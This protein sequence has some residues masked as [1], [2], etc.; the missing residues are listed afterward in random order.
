MD[1]FTQV[2]GYIVNTDMLITSVLC[3][4]AV[5]VILAVIYYQLDQPVQSVGYLS[6]KENNSGYTPQHPVKDSSS[7][8]ANNSDGVSEYQGQ[9]FSSDTM[10]L[11]FCLMVA[12][13]S[14]HTQKR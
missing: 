2:G 5:S 7:S 12:L 1:A 6:Y 10:Q 3:M 4:M 13:L 9:S 11:A 14:T 8:Y